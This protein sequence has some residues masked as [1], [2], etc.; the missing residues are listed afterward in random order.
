LTG[1]AGARVWETTSADGGYLAFDFE[2][3]TVIYEYSEAGRRYTRSNSISG[4]PVSSYF[5]EWLSEE[6][7]GLGMSTIPDL[8]RAI[9]T[10]QRYL[11]G[12]GYAVPSAEAF[13][14]FLKW[15]RTT[16][17]EESG[18]LLGESKR[19]SYA[20]YVRN[21]IAWGVREGFV[22]AEDADDVAER[23]TGAFRGSREREGRAIQEKAVAPDVLRRLYDAVLMEIEAAEAVLR[24]SS[25]ERAAYDPVLPVLMFPMLMGILLAARSVEWNTLQLHDIHHQPEQIWVHAPNKRPCS[26][27]AMPE[28]QRA[29][30]VAAAW[31]GAYR[32]DW[33]PDGPAI[34]VPH[35]QASKRTGAIPRATDEV[36]KLDTTRI[37]SHLGRF[38]M[39][40]FLRKRPTGMPVLYVEAGENGE[41]APF[42]LPLNE[43]RSAAITEYAR[44]ETDP[45]KLRRFARHEHLDTT[46]R[47]YVRNT[48]AEVRDVSART[49]G[50]FSERV[51]IRVLA[52]R[53]TR[54]EIEAATE[55]GALVPG[56]ACAEVLA[57][58]RR[59]RR[60][61][62][63]RLCE[64]FIIDL[65]KREWYVAEVVRFERRAEAAGEKN[66]SREVQVNL[67]MA[68]INTAIVQV[69]DEAEEV[70]V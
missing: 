3:G 10:F 15:M 64:F 1:V 38:Y 65:R 61:I 19:R 69:I 24:G 50:P 11:T 13:A 42:W 56:G 66:C 41:P 7:P 33:A 25:E 35:C 28:V 59:C 34:M 22:S 43:Y 23:F 62:D 40:Y 37:G 53:A 52:R 4:H 67:S 44:Y 68:A 54:E 8:V 47:H 57:G 48:P 55:K 36:V 70:L 32:T 49:I 5:V 46:M 45:E 26:L 9:K 18:R 58:L 20:G 63:C 29:W 31:Q 21:F 12:E 17:T 16:P 27:Y 30:A 51:R 39:K 2:S 6:A 60:A 14:G